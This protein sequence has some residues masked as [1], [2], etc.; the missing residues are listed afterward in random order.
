M[1]TVLKLSDYAKKINSDVKIIGIP[2]TIDNDLCMTD[3]TPALALPPN[4]S[5]QAC[6]R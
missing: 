5:H 1:D 2:K 4:I 3:H 6:L